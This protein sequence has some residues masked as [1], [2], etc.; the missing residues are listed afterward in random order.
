MAGEVIVKYT[1]D[2]ARVGQALGADVEV[3]GEGFAIITLEA[4]DIDKLAAF[5]EIVSVERPK[6]VTQSL[7]ESLNEACVLPVQQET[8]YGKLTGKGVLV[9]ILDSGVDFRHPD[10]R[11]NDGTSRIVYMW[12]QTGEG[13]PP[14]GFVHGTEYTAE[15]LNAALAGSSPLA[16]ETLLG[17]MSHGTAV[18]G[19]AAGNG[20]TSDGRNKGAAPE[21]GIIVVR[22]GETGRQSF[23]RTTE[24]MRAVKYVVDKAVEMNMPLCVNISYGTNDGPHRGTSLFAEYLDAMSQVWK[25]AFVVAMG[26]EGAAGHHYMG[27]LSQNETRDIQF[28]LQS[29][30]A[31]A[32]LTI[33][34]NFADI[35]TFELI[36]PNGHS[37][38]VLSTSNMDTNV[39]VGNTQVIGVYGQP[40]HYNPDQNIYYRLQTSNGR[41]MEGIWTLRVSAGAITDGRLDVWLP[42][43]QEVTENTAFVTPTPDGTL[44]IPSTA[45]GA[46]SV[47]AYDHARGS[48]ADFSGRGMIA[49]E[50]IKPDVVAPGVDIVAPMAGGGYDSFTGTSIAAPIVT[51]CAALMMQWGIVLGNDP[52][53]YGQRVKAFLRLGAA[54]DT[55][56]EYPNVQWGYGRVCLRASMDYLHDYAKK[57]VT[58]METITENLS[59]K[60]YENMSLIEF[61]RL[62]TTVGFNISD[63]KE[64]RQ[65]AEARPYIKIGSHIQGGYVIAYAPADMIEQMV[66]DL[67]RPFPVIFPII[68]TLTDRQSLTEAGIIKVHSTPGMDLQ[69]RGVLLGFVDTGIDYTNNAF[70]YEDGSSK[71][72]YIWDQSLV[73]KVPDRQ[74]LGAEYSKEEIDSALKA[75]NPFEIVPHKDDAGHGTFLASVAGGREHNEYIGAAPDSEIIMVKVR[76]TN[77]FFINY[78]GFN[79]KLD[80]IYSST[81]V[82]LGIK[83]ILEKAAQL[84]KPVAICIAMASNMGGHDGA[85]IFEQYLYNISGETGVAV[86]LSVGNEANS[87]HHT[88]GFIQKEGDTAEFEV[89]CGDNTAS[90]MLNVATS[91]HDRMLVS[92]V[93]PT[94][95]VI[96]KVPITGRPFRK[97]LTLEKSTVTVIYTL[98]ESNLTFVGVT[99]PTKGVWTIRLYGEI[100]LDGGFH[101]WIAPP[102]F[103]DGHVEFLTP[104]PNFTVV[105]P[106]TAIGPVTAGAYNQRDGSL[107]LASSWGPNRVNIINPDLVAPGVNVGGVTPHG[108][109][110]MSGTSVAAAITCGACAIALQWAI[111]EQNDMLMNTFR[112][113][114]FLIRGCDR[115]SDMTYPNNKWGYG[116]LN[117]YNAFSV[118]KRL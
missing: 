67:G 9:A 24:L 85:S 84:G 105:V 55:D 62:P 42:T 95:D 116:K 21:A 73:G 118:V 30:Q 92:V 68:L 51:G 108:Y 11:N 19:A 113:R 46:V 117:L 101:S 49:G 110:A 106:A 88:M 44:T 63:D 40:T 61:V 43:S 54:R 22:L 5:P 50:N 13:S 114:T 7:Y 57:G 25:S 107:Y 78:F 16:I 59:T 15:Q 48:I 103:I 33:W 29:A 52:F 34:K 31:S 100:I 53:L 20:R 58:V 72:A 64:F 6:I 96:N 27:V 37:N 93:S 83:Y 111:L 102:Q 75:E 65:Y 41:L 104:D 69:G 91:P 112:M 80:E 28:F 39:V 10:F 23:A 86:C 90:F 94:G 12:D 89:N 47:G 79:K 1:G 14:K 18:A 115:T 99:L 77:D 109:G 98:G 71:I 4:Q 3:L 70:R 76:K 36:A 81:D 8:K 26:N 60:Q 74:H 56:I 35:M 45:W 97:K 17:S 38:G 32:Y 82:M 2:I 87:K 66:K